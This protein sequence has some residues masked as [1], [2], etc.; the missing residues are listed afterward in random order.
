MFFHFKEVN[1]YKKGN[2]FIY[3]FVQAGKTVSVATDIRRRC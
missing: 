2:D 1:D 3:N